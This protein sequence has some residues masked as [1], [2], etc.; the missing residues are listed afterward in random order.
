MVVFPDS[1]MLCAGSTAPDQFRKPIPH[2]LARLLEGWERSS[3]DGPA[4]LEKYIRVLE[5]LRGWD[6]VILTKKT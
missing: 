1:E 2:K 3:S 6:A 4:D 5:G